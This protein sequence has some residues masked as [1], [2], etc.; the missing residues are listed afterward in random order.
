[1]LYTNNIV[2]YYWYIIIYIYITTMY[3]FIHNPKNGQKV[4]L[5]TPMGKNIVQMY[6][7]HLMGGAEPTI[8]EACSAVV[9]EYKQ[10]L[11][12]NVKL[13]QEAVT[14]QK[15]LEIA[16]DNV[17]GLEEVSESL[18]QCNE[19]KLAVEDILTKYKVSRRKLRKEI[20]RLRKE[21]EQNLL[22]KETLD[23]EVAN[24]LSPQSL[25]D[26]WP[27]SDSEDSDDGEVDTMDLTGNEQ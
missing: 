15:D 3:N 7:S 9:S 23:K 1:M 12:D 17:K 19:E 8:N 20:K 10:C 6:I 18:Y 11:T 26:Y 5:N 27:V 24:T 13:H 4:P 14:M 21:V 16:G 2:V 22:E 25:S